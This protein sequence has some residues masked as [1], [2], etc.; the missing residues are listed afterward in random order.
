M[1]VVLDG[2]ARPPSIEPAEENL[3]ALLDGLSQHLGFSLKNINFPL[4]HLLAIAP[5]EQVNYVLEQA[6][7]YKLVP[8]DL[9]GA[10]IDRYLQVYKHNLQAL[11]TYVPRA[12]SGNVILFK[13]SEQFAVTHKNPEMGWGDL[14]QRLVIHVVPGNHYSMLRE[15]H[16]QILA[17]N[18]QSRL[19]IPEAH[20]QGRI[21]SNLPSDV[22]LRRQNEQRW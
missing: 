9:G 13:A 12:Y 18:L 14:V 8:P 20:E 6:I 11:Q 5:E 7:A 16:V 19:Q 21:F 4:D 2:W 1:L 22:D 3:T 17:E 10:R 15:P